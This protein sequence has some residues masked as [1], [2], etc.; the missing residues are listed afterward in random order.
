[1]VEQVDIRTNGSVGNGIV[2]ISFVSTLPILP[3]LSENQL[4]N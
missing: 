4:K 3:T 1:M 2:K